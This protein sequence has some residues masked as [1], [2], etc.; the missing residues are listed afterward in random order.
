MPDVPVKKY[1]VR[2]AKKWL[3]RTL[4]PFGVR[5]GKVRVKWNKADTADW[6]PAAQAD[7]PGLARYEYSWL[8]QNGED[9]VIR[10]LFD[11]LGYESRWFVEFG[12]GAVQCNSLRLM[13]HEN[14]S[15]LLMDGSSENVEFFNY[16]AKKM[17]IGGARAV[18]AFITL[19]NLEDLIRG[20]EVPREID[21][22]SLDVDGNDYWF[23]EA[24]ACVSPRVVCI[25]YNA[26]LG[27]DLS[28]TVPYDPEFERYSK[29]PSGFFHGASLAALESLGKRKGYYLIGCDSTGTNAFF[30]R[31]DI[32]VPDVPAV[33]AREAF[34]PHA[35]WLGR[36]ISEA[37]QLV[38][39]QSM[40]YQE[41]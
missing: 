37:E 9:G 17:G 32:V 10:F 40:P 41:V 7:V 12:F 31:D 14:F 36:G 4:V 8:S 27:P 21:F 15:G 19:D 22:L 1:R 16:T 30:L 2:R 34:R 18:Q 20:N 25:E 39:M 24:L 35:N 5:A 13:K 33:T 28:A 3:V 26:G 38:I 29:H 6:P 11:Q 23:W